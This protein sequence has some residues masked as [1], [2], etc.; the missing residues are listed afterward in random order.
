MTGCIL[1]KFTM[2]WSLAD[3]AA[4]LAKLQGREPQVKFFHR[5]EK[6]DGAF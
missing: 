4:A 3:L 5:S 1:L 2:K 6:A